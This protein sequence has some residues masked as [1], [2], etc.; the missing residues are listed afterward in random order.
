ML[1]DLE[2]CPD[3]PTPND[4]N[5]ENCPRQN[6]ALVWHNDDDGPVVAID[7]QKGQV[8]DDEDRDGKFVVYF[9]DTNEYALVPLSDLQDEAWP[10]RD[11]PY[12]LLGPAE[13]WECWDDEEEW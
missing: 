11:R 1:L 8:E 10:D 7:E 13:D 3:C 5:C 9:F 4:A 12:I 6:N 2:I